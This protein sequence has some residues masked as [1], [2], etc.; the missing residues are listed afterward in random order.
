[1]RG[2]KR[3]E[4]FLKASCTTARLGVFMFGLPKM[5]SV[6]KT[7]RS[8]VD[9]GPGLRARMLRFH[10]QDL[11]VQNEIGCFWGAT[12]A[13]IAESIAER[14]DARSAWRPSRWRS[15]AYRLK[16]FSP[17]DPV[18]ERGSAR[19]KRDPQSVGPD[20]FGELSA[21]PPSPPVAQVYL[22]D[23]HCCAGCAG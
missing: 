19:G 16:P 17:W 20:A 13:R 12:A 15:E 2:I 18:V 14:A 10:K 23:L 7:A 1:M 21:P 5:A 22:H 11:K 6:A 8:A 4:H 3:F 9:R